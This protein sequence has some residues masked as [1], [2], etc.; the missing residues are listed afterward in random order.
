METISKCAKC[1]CANIHSF[2]FLLQ[3]VRSKQTIYMILLKYF[4]G[5]Q[6]GVE[7]AVTCDEGGQ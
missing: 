4:H 1:V 7:N 5:L 3:L 2:I 6:K